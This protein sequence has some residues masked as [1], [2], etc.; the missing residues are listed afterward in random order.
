VVTGFRKLH[1]STANTALLVAVL[2]RSLLELLLLFVSH[3]GMVLCTLVEQYL[4]ASAGQLS[5]GV[6]LADGIGDLRLRIG[7][8][9]GGVQKVS[10]GRVGAI[11]SESF[12]VS[13][14]VRQ[15][16]R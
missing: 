16:V 4:A 13:D 7:D 14:L 1:S 3:T 2:D 11:H 5:A 6:V 10:T 8:V 15:Q 12:V 9:A